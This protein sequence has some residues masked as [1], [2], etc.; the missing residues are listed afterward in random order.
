MSELV[1]A[2]DGG[3][4]KTDLALVGRDGGVLALVRG[5][6]SSP[7]HIGIEGSVEVLQGLFAEAVSEAGLV[8][9]NGPVAAA[10][11]LC[12]AG[13]DFPAEQRE[14]QRRV[15]A[16]EW[17][18]RAVVAND[19][20]AVL[21]AGTPHGWGVG[22]VC[23]AGINCVA[24][25]P[26]GREVRFPALGEITGDWGGGSDVGAAALWSAA[27][28]ADGRGPKTTLEQSV[29]AHFGLATP[30]EV[31]EAIHLG[32]VPQRRLLEL[33]PL[34]F[35]E[36]KRDDV[37]RTIVLRLLDEIAAFVRA[38]LTRLTLTHREVD[39]AIGGGVT[40]SFDEATLSELGERLR[41]VAP[42][43]RLHTTQAPPVLGAALSALGAI[44]ADGEAR[45]RV[46]RE[47]ETTWRRDG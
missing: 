24:V 19:T 28:S 5:P 30:D 17:A 25:A 9:R 26:D 21:W 44:G 32:R 15:D 16:L 31:A 34:V 18:T 33:S 37:A 29:P 40:R 45:A 6:L 2:V 12:M 7:H 11:Q 35:L 4:S 27:R 3:N 47:L 46:R 39:V 38:S 43:V 36:A 14:L 20:Y 1:V 10:G 8:R 22:L 13:I 23:G 42:H 41:E